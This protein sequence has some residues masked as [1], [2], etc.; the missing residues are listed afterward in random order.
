MPVQPDCQGVINNVCVKAESAIGMAA[1]SM[2][3]ANEGQHSCRATREAHV[4][5]EHHELAAKPASTNGMYKSWKH[6]NA[7]DDCSD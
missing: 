4:H 7:A 5:H 3:A 2:N 6:T 1:V